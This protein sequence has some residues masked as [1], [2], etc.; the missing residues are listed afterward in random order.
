MAIHYLGQ[1]IVELDHEPT[2]ACEV[3]PTL[4]NYRNI[5]GCHC[6]E[7]LVG[8]V[9]ASSGRRSALVTFDRI[10]AIRIG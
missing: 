1:M 5:T 9:V 4:T 8:A 7:R 3:G 6:D 10:S 2:Q